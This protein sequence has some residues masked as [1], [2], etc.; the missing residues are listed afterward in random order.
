MCMQILLGKRKEWQKKVVTEEY[1]CEKTP[2]LR[3]REHALRHSLV[4][5]RYL[6]KDLLDLLFK[7]HL[8]PDLWSFNL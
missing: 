5:Q 3:N 7:V 1:G 2:P 8:V 4:T 6:R